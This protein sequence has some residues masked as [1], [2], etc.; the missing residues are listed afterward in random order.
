[1]RKFAF[2]ASIALFVVAC[3]V[4]NEKNKG[5]GFNIFSVQD[6]IALGA[7]VA[8]EIESD[9]AQFPILDSMQY[10]EAY[11]YVYKVRDKILNTGLIDFKDDF[12]WRLRIIHDDST[13]NAFCTPG[14]YIYIYTGILKF[15]DDESQFAGVMGHEMAHADMRHSTRSMTKMFGVQ[16][17]LD[18][19]AGDRAAIKQVTGALIGLKFSRTHEIEA[20]EKSVDYLCPTDYV[21]SGGAGFFRKIEEMGGGRVPEF[22]STHPDPGNRIE[23]FEN[24]AL[25]NG[26]KGQQVFA[27]EYAAMKAK[28]P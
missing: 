9:P 25:V 26:C 21:A 22:L 2:M 27:S 7:Q 17:L 16:V 19:I 23:N 6:D 14:G 8:A 5:K 4:V 3:G 28:L 11:Q 1:M 24:N 15:L 18:V 20:D 13:L 12:G 10:P